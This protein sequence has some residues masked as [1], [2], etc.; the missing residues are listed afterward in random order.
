M[1]DNIAIFFPEIPQKERSIIN[2]MPLEDDNKMNQEMFN[3]ER[4]QN[5][6]SLRKK[7]LAEI[8]SSKRNSNTNFFSIIENFSNDK[9]ENNTR[10]KVELTKND[11][12]SGNIYLQLKA[13]FES[14]NEEGILDLLINISNYFKDKKIDRIGLKELFI[15]S[16]NNNNDSN[17]KFPFAYLLLNIG[18]NTDN[19]K[20]YTYCFN[21]L[22]NITFISDDFCK[23]ITND[24][25]I[26]IILEKLIYFYPIYNN[27]ND[28]INLNELNSVVKAES[29]YNGIQILKL[30]GNLYICSD[31]YEIFEFND[32]YDKIFYLLYIFNLDEKNPDYIKHYSEFL[33]TLIWLIN[34]FKQSDET[35][36]INYKDKILMII[37][38]LFEDAKALQYTQETNILYQIIELLDFLCDTNTDFLE[39]TVDAGGIKILIDLFD[40]LFN[41]NINLSNEIVLN[42]NIIDKILDIFINVFYL[43]SKCFQFFNE[44]KAFSKLIEELISMY[45]FHSQNHYELQTKLIKLLSNLACFNDIDEIINNFLL[46]KNII[47]DLFNYYYPYH[48][49]E[50]IFFISN[51]METQSKKVRDFILDLG[52]FEIIKNNI[53][54][55]KEIN[56]EIMKISIKALYQLIKAEKSNNIRLLFEKMYYTAIPDKIKELVFDKDINND[57][58]NE[59]FIDN[60]NENISFIFKSLINDFE[61]YEKSLENN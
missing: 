46:N 31:S 35:F 52:A 13:L 12:T 27:N 33:E 11:F 60:E 49:F 14:K 9:K 39:Q 57:N 21:F 48:K 10:T 3:E 50:I 24:K 4:I 23:E 30:L 25:C 34:L 17:E 32:F 44:Y 41:T 29:F 7:K 61:I 22:L 37:P 45:K 26:S 36:I 8:I 6:L 15:I 19:K 1:N 59:N 38:K 42:T 58:N 18:I 40:Y 47:I 43:D 2:S 56:I 55:N 5:K 16:I 54:I 51:I 28:L 53:C 20:I